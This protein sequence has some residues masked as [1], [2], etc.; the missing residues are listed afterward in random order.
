[1]F[2]ATA[3]LLYVIGTEVPKTSYLTVIDKLVVAVLVVRGQLDGTRG[4]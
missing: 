2:L 3:A 4:C 1:M